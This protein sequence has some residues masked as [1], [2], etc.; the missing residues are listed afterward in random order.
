[1]LP[2]AI[3]ELPAG[4]VVRICNIPVELLE[5]VKA[6]AAEDNWRLIDGRKAE[7]GDGRTQGDL[8]GGER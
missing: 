4:T 2:Q 1:M 3:H 8:F 6:T 5:P 7:D